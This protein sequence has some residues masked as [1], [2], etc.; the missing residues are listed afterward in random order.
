MTGIATGN[1]F[2]VASLYP[3]AFLLPNMIIS[4]FVTY[5]MA[6]AKAL[7]MIG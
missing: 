7:R 3:Q 4:V 6:A 1:F 5:S 2:Q